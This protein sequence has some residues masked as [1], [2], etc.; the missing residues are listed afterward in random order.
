MDDIVYDN[1]VYDDDEDD[2]DQDEYQDQDLAET[3][4]PLNANKEREYID[5]TSFQLKNKEELRSLVKDYYSFIKEEDNIEP[6]KVDITNFELGEDNKT[7]FLK[8]FGRPNIK[9]S[10]RGGGFI[11]LSTLEREIGV[12]NIRKKLLN[13]PDY[14]K[15]SSQAVKSLQNVEKDMEKQINSFEDIELDDLADV[16]ETAVKEVIKLN[17]DKEVQT[18]VDKREMDKY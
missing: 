18:I 2:V 10:K 12:R 16:T 15:L 4:D 3:Y 9:L 11:K 14:K 6:T 17:D 1:P 13:L 5:T 8:V 7:L